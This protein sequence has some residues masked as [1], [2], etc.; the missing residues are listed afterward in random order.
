MTT[1]LRIGLLTVVLAA[2]R[3]QASPTQS[4]NDQQLASLVDSLMP[5]VA[6]A[7][8]LEFKSTPK[9][10]VRTRAQIHEFLIAKMARE[11]PDSRVEG[12]SASF[13]LLDLIPDS[14]DLRALFLDLYTEQ[15]A[16]FY[17]PDSAKLF[18]VQGAEPLQLHLVLAHELVHALQDQYVPLDSILHDATDGDRQGAAQAV[19]E[20]Q[21]TVASLVALAPTMDVW[22]SDAFW[23]TFRKQLAA[24]RVDTG[25]YGRA[26]MAIREGLTFPYLAGSD[27]VRWF[28]QHQPGSPPYGAKLPTSTEQILHPER[29]VAHDTPV[30]VAIAGDT[31][32]K[33][34]EDTF[35]EFD[36]DLLHAHLLHQDSVPTQPAIGWGG[37]RFRIFHT[38]TGPAMVWYT[39]WDDAASAAAFKRQVADPI[40]AVPRTGYRKIAVP[41]QIDGHPGVRIVIAPVTWPGW[42]ALPGATA[43]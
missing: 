41:L 38:A 15:I 3:G 2:C 5:T 11:L 39:V 22:N 33:I 23:T 16:G 27:F 18:A 9:S 20:G 13:R 8:G 35:G 31:T 32:G 43:Q 1:F 17:D 24:Q 30:R 7:A 19:M 40:A 37:D 26:P 25:V 42:Q 28:H 12:I 34:F 6:R 4:V 29:Y 14:L 21:A 10:A 36:I